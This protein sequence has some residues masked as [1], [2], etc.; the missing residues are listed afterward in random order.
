LIGMILMVN[1]RK[2]S[3]S[4]ES[5]KA[6]RVD[7]LPAAVLVKRQLRDRGRPVRSHLRVGKLVASMLR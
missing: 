7:A 2:E 3:G 5:G 1:E 4:I 6:I